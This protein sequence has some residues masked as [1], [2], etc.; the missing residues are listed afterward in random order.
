[1]SS[2]SP[3]RLHP[4]T[5]KPSKPLM[6]YDGDC[7]FCRLWIKRWRFLT[8][9]QVDYRP[10]QETASRYPEIPLERFQASVHL[11]EPHGGVYTG[12][13]AVFQGLSYRKGLGWLPGAYGRVPGLSWISERA[14]GF[15]ATHRGWFSR[16]GSCG[17]APADEKPSYRISRWFFVKMLALAFLAAFLSL[18]AQVDG[19]VG[20]SGLLPVQSFLSEVQRQMGVSS[21]FALPTLC[22]LNDSDAF[23]H[24]LCGAGAFLSIALLLDAVPALC[25]FLL[26][27]F[28]LSLVKAGQ[29]FLCF[30]WDI[31]L[32][33][34]GFLAFLASP[35]RSNPGRRP[36]PIS[37][38]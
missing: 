1:M 16:A 9:D 38:P 33:E 8:G 36:G 6:V 3:K 21:F 19:L 7:G 27:L 26:W 4:E 23:L 31:L 32:L 22:W 34:A 24:F 14:Y 25:L 18:G 10:Y 35:W 20:S 5:P 15:V 28:Y 17:L 12:A 13:Q 11:V 37:R 29:D 30:Q 2:P